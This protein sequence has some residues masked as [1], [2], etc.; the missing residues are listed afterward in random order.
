MK[1]VKNAYSTNNEPHRG[2]PLPTD[3]KQRLENNI[4]AESF[5]LNSLDI[6]KIEHRAQ[7]LNALQE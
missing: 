1:S 3:A 7:E 2:N 6:D 4:L 5:N